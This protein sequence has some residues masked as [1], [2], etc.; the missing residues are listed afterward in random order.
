MFTP[1][2]ATMLPQAIPGLDLLHVLGMHIALP[3]LQTFSLT[4]FGLDWLTR[5]LKGVSEAIIKWISETFAGEVKKYIVIEDHANSPAIRDTYWQNAELAGYLLLFFI[6]LG[7][8]E[9]PFA[10]AQEFSMEKIAIRVAKFIIAVPVALEL[11]PLLVTLV[12][13]VTLILYPDSF[14]MVFEGG[15]LYGGIQALGYSALILSIAGYFVGA[16]SAL[17]ILFGLV[18]LFLREYAY[19]IL[20]IGFPLLMSA[21]VI[22]WGVM[23][24][25]YS[26]VNIL[27]FM[28]AA[29][30]LSG[31]IIA[32]GLQAGATMLGSGA[33]LTFWDKFLTWMITMGIVG[34]IPIKLA[35]SAQFTMS[36]LQGGSGSSSSSGSGSGSSTDSGSDSSGAS[37]RDQAGMAA[38][39]AAGRVGSRAA[40]KFNESDGHFAGMT[41]GGIGHHASNMKQEYSEKIP[42]RAKS[43]AGTAR[44]VASR[45]GQMAKAG[46]S[47]MA[48]NPDQSLKHWA[49]DTTEPLRED[50][51]VDMEGSS[52]DVGG[53][54]AET[55]GASSAGGSQDHTGGASSGSDRRAGS[56]T[57]GGRT[58][59][60]AQSS[61]SGSGGA[62]DRS[63]SSST[64]AREKYE[65][66]P[67]DYGQQINPSNGKSFANDRPD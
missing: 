56:S 3:E 65:G 34:A 57:S 14:N 30:I 4:G 31:P 59:T 2:L 58:S 6:P 23:G 46:A 44:D 53:S 10:D 15:G 54:G 39:R 36:R 18:G 61:S 33:N 48:K 35:S 37:L 67:R 29:L 25:V 11:L 17:A 1:L 47:S 20:L 55:A 49:K 41:T 50:P 27:M 28:L 16:I 22:S 63:S 32:L 40:N 45:A 38:G 64:S 43:A 21:R 24:Y 7:L 8:I 52:G 42:D 66:T 12:N 9:G 60:G 5:L 62:S 13:D 19:T 26:V 51:V